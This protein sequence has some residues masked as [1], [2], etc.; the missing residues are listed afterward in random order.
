V[1]VFAALSLVLAIISACTA[2]V[3]VAA[4]VR[5][6]RRTS[7]TGSGPSNVVRL[8]PARRGEPA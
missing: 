2:F 1:F 7:E 6:N 3:A 8:H 5:A 4:L